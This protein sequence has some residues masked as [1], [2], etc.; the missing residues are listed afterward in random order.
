MFRRGRHHC[1]AVPMTFRL[2]D[3]MASVV[4]SVLMVKPFPHGRSSYKYCS[5]VDST[6]I[7]TG[8]WTQSQSETNAVPQQ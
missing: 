7:S 1:N 8:M 6:Q 5:S 3:V 2:S 4:R